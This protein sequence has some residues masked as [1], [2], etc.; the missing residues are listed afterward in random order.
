MSTCGRRLTISQRCAALAP[1]DTG[2]AWP[3]QSPLPP[4]G[5]WPPPNAAVKRRPAWEAGPARWRLLSIC[6]RFPL[7]GSDT[8]KRP[9][10]PVKG[11]RMCPV[12]QPPPFPE[13]PVPLTRQRGQKPRQ[14]CSV[15]GAVRGAGAGFLGNPGRRGQGQASCSWNP[16]PLGNGLGSG[17][18]PAVFTPTGTEGPCLLASTW[19]QRRALLWGRRHG[20]AS[21]LPTFLHT[22]FTG[23][24]LRSLSAHRPLQGPP[25]HPGRAD[26]RYACTYA[27]YCAYMHTHHTHPRCVHVHTL[28]TCTHTWMC[29]PCTRRACMYV[30]THGAG[31]TQRCSCQSSAGHPASG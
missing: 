3:A 8:R 29:V 19:A 5:A 21:R 6:E 27:Q 4:S 22:T 14:C 31:R 2:R 13:V 18:G 28:G 12:F 9:G 11:N 23:P 15:G 24:C 26:T 10:V 25:W 20:S 7:R 17:Q 30:C 16:G 1:A